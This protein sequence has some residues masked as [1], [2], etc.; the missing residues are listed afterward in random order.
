MVEYSSEGFS[1]TTGGNLTN[2]CVGNY[3]INITDSY[4]CEYQLSTD[5]SFNLD[6]P[7]TDGD[8]VCD[9]D[10]IPG[11]VDITACNY[12]MDA[13]EDDE[14]CYFCT[15]LGDEIDSNGID[16]CEIV[17]F[18]A[19][20]NGNPPIFD[21]NGCINDT[22][23][24]GVCDELEQIGCTDNGQQIWSVTPGYAA[25]TY[26][27]DATEPCEDLDGDGI[28]DCCEYPAEFYLTCD[29]ECAD[30][31]ING[32]FIID[33]EEVGNGDIDND[34]VC[35]ILEIEGCQEP[36][37]CNYDASATDPGTCIYPEEFYNCDGCIIDTDEDGVC[38][39]LEI[40]GCQDGLAC[41][42]DPEATDPAECYYLELS[43]FVDE[44][45]INVSCPGASDGSFTIYTTGGIGPYSILY[46]R[47]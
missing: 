1:Y 4:N 24:D 36:D 39:E 35:N 12:D 14:S 27:S 33:L 19:D 2:A 29:D 38:D 34:G 16:D 5:V 45:I 37:A 46:R 10:E 23:F 8:G 18:N 22:D 15:G 7:D 40:E 47:L 25:C 9:D 6:N 3:I 28:Q 43:T 11:C 30:T 41:N 32:N 42:F 21:C 13:T 20:E 44:N 31:D 26:D 17:N